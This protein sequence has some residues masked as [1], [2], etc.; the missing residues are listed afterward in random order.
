M[1]HRRAAIAAL[2]GGIA[3]A[4]DARA[5]EW[6]SRKTDPIYGYSCCGGFDCAMLVVKPGVL[7]A[8]PEGYRIRLTRE[9]T[10]KINPY[11]VAPIDALVPWSRVQMSEDGNYHICLMTF[12][13]G[14]PRGGIYCFF[15][16]PDS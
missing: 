11:S 5:H 1:R 14:A 15:A 10:Q 8:E 7:T 2:L 16:P 12:F 6:Y 4:A 3:V 9:E 13:R